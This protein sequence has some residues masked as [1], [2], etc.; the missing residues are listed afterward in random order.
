[1]NQ[2]IFKSRWIA[3]AFAT[4]T[5]FSVWALVGDENDGG[6]FGGVRDD[7]VEQRD[8]T[9]DQ[10][11]SISAEPPPTQAAPEM[12]VEEEFV[13][14]SELIDGAMGEDPT[15][16]GGEPD[17]GADDGDGSSDSTISD[18]PPEIDG[19]NVEE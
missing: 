4:L 18:T 10:L 12:L 19:D 1:M 17:S 5:L 9:A 8:E 6:L 16:D 3:I 7:L 13:D 11:S 15:P 2:F 14:D